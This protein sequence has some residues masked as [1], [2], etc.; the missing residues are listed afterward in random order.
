MSQLVLGTFESHPLRG[1]QM[2]ARSIDVEGEHRHRGAERIGLAP[3]AALSGALER[4]RN[5]PGGV[6][7]EDTRLQIQRSARFGHALRPSLSS[8]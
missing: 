6:L 8:T 2:L 7:R 3:S 5:S 1:R 4:T